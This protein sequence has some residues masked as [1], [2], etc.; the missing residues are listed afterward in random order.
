MD[1][2]MIFAV[3]FYTFMTG[4]TQ[5]DED[6]AKPP[7][8]F[9]EEWKETSEETPV[10]QANVNNGNLVLGLHGSGKNNIKKSHHDKPLNHPYYIWYGECEGAWRLP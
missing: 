1:K 4:N 9:R 10:T 6:R 7:L 3:V 8:Y 5:A 2:K